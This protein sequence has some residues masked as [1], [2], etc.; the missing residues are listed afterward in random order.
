MRGTHT[1][2]ITVV[3]GGN[4]SEPAGGA[5]LNGSGA[6][7]AS[8]TSM[9]IQPF[10]SI[11]VSGTATAGLPLIDFNGAD[12]V[13][14]N[15]LNSGGNSL[16]ISN[17]STSSTSGTS[18]IRFQTDATN[19][20][21]TNCSVLGSATMAVGTNGGNIWFGS[22]AVTTGNDNNTIS[23]CNIG[24][25]GA[26]LPSKCIYFSGSSNTDPGTANNGII[27]NN[28]NIF[29]YFSATVASAGID[30]NSGSTNLTISNN[31]FYETATR[32]QT[33]GSQHNAIRI[34][35]TSGNNYQVTGNTI[36]FASSSGTGTY[37]F[38]AV[39]SSSV[40]IPIFLSVGT[41]TST[42]V[43]GNTIAGIAMSGAGSGTSSSGAFRGIYVNSGLTNIG[44]ITGNTVGSMSATGSITYTS[45]SSS[46]S[47]VMG[48][49]NFGSSNW[50]SNNKCWWY[51]CF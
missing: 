28:N 32:T 5:I 40:L 18:T 22:A 33:T 25:A 39:S 7:S 43:Q 6:G 13:T 45:S 46:A 37:S 50:I 42:S 36:G 21:I 11:T 47:D 10:G 27:I 34:S 30:L 24:P 14:V 9:S 8:Y 35:N 41:T 2:T 4:T 20:T 26:N 23:N 31:R 17:L 15:G 19:N 12:N 16:T 38:V 3:I 1:G 51:H 44:D 49:F 48:I 29:D